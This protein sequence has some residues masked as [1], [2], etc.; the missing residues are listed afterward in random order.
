MTDDEVER[1]RRSFEVETPKMVNEIT[2][3]KVRFTP[4]VLIS[5]KPY[6]LWHPGSLKT[7][8]FYAEELLNEL[9]TVAKP[10][11]FDSVGYY[12]LHYDTASGYKVPRGGYGVGWY[13]TAH[14]LGIFGVNCNPQMSPRGEIFLHEW[15]HGLDGFYGKKPGVKL[16]KGSLHGAVDHGYVGKQGLPPDKGKGSMDWY[17]DYITANVKEGMTTSGL[18]SMAWKYGPPRNVALKL[19][20]N[21][22][23]ANLP[24]GTYPGWVYEL[25]KGDLSHAVLGPPIFKEQLEPGPIEKTLWKLE[26][27]NRKAGTTAAVDNT[28]GVALSI[29]NPSP[30]SAR[31]VRMVPLEPS[32]NYVFS[33]DVKSEGVEITEAGGRY[34]VNLYAGDSVSTKDLSGSKDWTTVVLP[35]TTGP[36]AESCQLKLSIGGFAS[37][38]RGRA[39]FRNVQVR[40]IGYPTKKPRGR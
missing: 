32:M 2:G 37:V 14:A 36:K 40:L 23:P 31:L 12:F 28:E 26:M 10:G 24:V 3:G 39:Y 20:A 25:M 33:A 6:R 7:A 17:R 1:V 21:Y 29:N 4:T 18:G 13:D 16:P 15:M 19:T 38:A 30:N 9:T 11:D 35:F 34:A 27:W 22:R 5:E 8:G